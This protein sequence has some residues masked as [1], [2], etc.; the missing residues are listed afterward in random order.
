MKKKIFVGGLILLALLITAF[1][2]FFGNGGD[3]NKSQSQ[4]C[5]NNNCFIVQLAET[6][7]EMAR[8]LMFR[9]K[10]ETNGGM[11]FIFPKEEIYSFWMENTLIPLDII[12]IDKNKK[13]VFIAKNVQP[14]K[15]KKCPI[16]TPSKEAFY[17]LEINAGLADKIGLSVGDNLIFKL[18]Q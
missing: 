12:W 7:E 10:L 3:K 8:G 4:V 15:I 18:E 9:E 14:C 1:F 6:P 11:L 16:T 13:V 2:V 5:F 17:V